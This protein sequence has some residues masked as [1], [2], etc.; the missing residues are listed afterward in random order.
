M[1]NANVQYTFTVIHHLELLRGIR[2]RRR[3]RRRRRRRRRSLL[4]SFVRSFVASCVRSFVRSLLRSFVRC[5]V[6]S[7]VR[8]FVASFVR[9]F[10]CVRS[11]GGQRCALCSLVRPARTA[12]KNQQRMNDAQRR[13]FMRANCV[14][15]IHS[16]YTLLVVAFHCVITRSCCVIL[17]SSPTKSQRCTQCILSAN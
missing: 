8:L 4:R 7:F 6:R 11:G 15:F 17:L 9:S 1:W 10:C 12:P 2:R 13:E 3:C 16:T 5:F 14:R